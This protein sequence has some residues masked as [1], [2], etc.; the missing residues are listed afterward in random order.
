MGA[1]HNHMEGQH[2][3]ADGQA[4]VGRALVIGILLNTVFV[5]I[6]A[7][8]GFWQQSLALLSDA[9]HNLFD[10]GSLALALL[11]FRL[12]RVPP[13]DQYTYG[14]RKTTILVALANAVI[15]LIA[16]GG[17]GFEAVQRF[18]HPAPL[19]GGVMAIVAGAGI[20]I[21]GFTAFL[22]LRDRDKDLNIQG[23]YLHMAADA[24]VSLG[25]VAG[26][27]VIL[28]TGWYW[29]DP[30]ISFLVMAVILLST[31]GLLRD[32]LRLSLDGVPR[33]VDMEAVRGA[34][35]DMPGVLDMHHIHVWAMSTTQNALTA[36]LVLRP[37]TSLA[38]AGGIK[39]ALRKKLE[40]LHIG[41]ST[42]ETETGEGA[43]QERR[44]APEAGTMTELH[45]HAHSH[46]HGHA[47]GHLH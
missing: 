37:G 32:S 4:H 21:N 31:W 40:Q 2:A 6:E 15:L 26:G 41:H 35:L 45:G 11:A 22:F 5:V 1:P 29:V 43:C 27:L 39:D 38:E 46:G 36:H 13:S 18:W 14:Y 20:L 25:V 42:F 44:C 16:V 3:V 12:S 33:D 47:H 23:A 17:I 24:L 10:V 30:L 9:G 34:A 28:F 8:A 7:A 19:D